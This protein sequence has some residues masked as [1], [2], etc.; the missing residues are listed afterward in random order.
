[1]PSNETF[2]KVQFSGPVTDYRSTWD[3][4]SES[5]GV[6]PAGG[7][8]RCDV[9]ASSE[10][11]GYGGVTFACTSLK[12]LL[13]ELSFT[14]PQNIEQLF[15]DGYDKGDPTLTPL[16]FGWFSSRK[17]LIRWKWSF[18]LQT[19]PTRGPATYELVPGK[20]CGHFVADESASL[21]NLASI[22]VFILVGTNRRA[23]FTLRRAGIGL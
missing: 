14:N 13:L 23:G 7:G 2:K 15:V 4:Y 6:L 1:M 10:R 21:E 5:V 16:S 18:G 11:S 3:S 12:S 19:M 17:R 9:V 22:D 20:P 8:L